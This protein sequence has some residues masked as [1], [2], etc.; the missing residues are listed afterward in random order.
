MIV[1][2]SGIF[3]KRS[4]L[5]GAGPTRSRLVEEDE[6]EEDSTSFL[7]VLQVASLI[8]LVIVVVLGVV[9]LRARRKVGQR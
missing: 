6:G 2:R 4:F 1:P 9:G 7:D 5:A 3:D 8:L